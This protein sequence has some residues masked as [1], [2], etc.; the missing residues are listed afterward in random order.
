MDLQG[1]TL[2]SE[3]FFD[4]PQRVVAASITWE[5]LWHRRRVSLPVSIGGG[6]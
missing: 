5:Y 4:I 6:K 1:G 3:N 2:S